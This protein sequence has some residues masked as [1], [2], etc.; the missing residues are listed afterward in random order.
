MA[1]GETPRTRPREASGA[2]IPHSAPAATR[3]PSISPRAPI[4]ANAA[5]D[6]RFPNAPAAVA[7]S[8]LSN[9]RIEPMRS[10]RPEPWGRQASWAPA[11]VSRGP[12]SG[13]HRPLR[14]G[15]AAAKAEARSAPRPNVSDSP[16][17][18]VGTRE[19]CPPGISPGPRLTPTRSGVDASFTSNRPPG[20]GGPPGS[21]VSV[22]PRTKRSRRSP[23][24]GLA[25]APA[26]PPISTQKGA[27]SAS[28]IAISRP[29]NAAE[30]AS[31]AALPPR[32]RLDG[33]GAPPLESAFPDA[34]V[35]APTGRVAASR[36][37]RPRPWSRTVRNPTDRRQGR[38]VRGSRRRPPP[39][40]ASRRRSRR[41]APAVRYC[42]A[43]R[44][45][46]A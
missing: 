16:P 38:D 13:A 1:T 40:R 24:D 4:P 18:R 26:K 5:P 10:A 7:P 33:A 3:H 21:P 22:S 20:A 39:G 11:A 34:M 31:P 46:S 45:T 32:N 17:S 23:I 36:S 29:R 14:G 42:R 28:K 41:V 9:S 43:G 37:I 35:N 44:G 6:A 2:A 30:S 15:G 12:A 8:A 25:A 19:A 27:P